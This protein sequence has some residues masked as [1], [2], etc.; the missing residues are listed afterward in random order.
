MQTKNELTTNPEKDNNPYEA[1]PIYKE[2]K[3]IKYINLDGAPHSTA[4]ID[5]YFYWGFF[6]RHHFG[7]KCADAMI[8]KAQDRVRLIS[9][10]LPVHQTR[11]VPE[12][13]A[14]KMTP[15]IFKSIFIKHHTPVVL[16]GLARE[17]SCVKKWTP[18]F[19][20]KEYGQEKV[21]VRIAASHKS[22]KGHEV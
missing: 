5:W 1:N 6:I 15:E 8:E 3:G 22:L 7:G 14:D 10:S 13:S 2:A 11:P 20:S 16:R 21:R 9:K 12:Y 17:F 18:D 4:L 19:F